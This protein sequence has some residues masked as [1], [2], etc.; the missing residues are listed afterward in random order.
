ME[1]EGDRTRGE[2]QA[3]P[4][5]GR[6]RQD[7]VVLPALAEI[8]AV[9][10]L[11]L[12]HAQDL[13]SD[14]AELAFVARPRGAAYGFDE[15]GV[16][17][18]AVAQGR[19][20]GG[21]EVVVGQN[22]RKVDAA[23][24]GR[25]DADDR[26]PLREGVQLRLVVLEKRGERIGCVACCSVVEA[27]AGDTHPCVAH[28]HPLRPAVARDQRELHRSEPSTA[29]EVR[30]LGGLALQL[31]LHDRHERGRPRGDPHGSVGRAGRLRRGEERLARGDEERDGLPVR[32]ADVP[33]A[34][35][36][37]QGQDLRVVPG[38][39]D[40][41]LQR[42]LLGGRDL[43]GHHDHTARPQDAAHVEVL[44]EGGERILGC[45]LG[46]VR[47][48]QA[49]AAEDQAADEQAAEERDRDR[50]GP[51][52]RQATTVSG[53]HDFPQEGRTPS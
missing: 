52:R 42:C 27:P 45:R 23:M 40:S 18:Q 21:E 33:D 11:R 20:S 24:V 5:T 16:G 28:A 49:Q 43:Q 35:G 30:P 4:R 26:R 1:G 32:D 47:G 46:R 12:E 6:I 44:Q 19:P 37:G 38:Q 31:T 2:A 7:P 17:D 25:Q 36:A 15:D 8:G 29:T 50:R 14:A 34:G 13:K 3:V 10:R 9:Q 53:A 39:T 22:A 48:T 51:D 41:G